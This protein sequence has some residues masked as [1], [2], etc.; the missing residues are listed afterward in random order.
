M[1]KV[2][3][4]GQKMFTGCLLQIKDGKEQIVIADWRG[5]D[6]YDID[7]FHNGIDAYALIN[8]D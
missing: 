1:E 5:A 8:E 4:S 6:W 2:V 7:E 3:R